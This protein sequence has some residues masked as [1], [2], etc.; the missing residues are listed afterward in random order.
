MA[1]G[2]WSRR[3]RFLVVTPTSAQ[4]DVTTSRPSANGYMRGT[5]RLF[6]PCSAGLLLLQWTNTA[7]FIIFFNSGKNDVMP[8]DLQN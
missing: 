5:G 2:H 7:F 8:K 6:S 3:P 4:G 1:K